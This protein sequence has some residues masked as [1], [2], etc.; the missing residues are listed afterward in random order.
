MN[1]SGE[2]RLKLIP[3]SAAGRC[4]AGRTGTPVSRW[5]IA[6]TRLLLSTV[7]EIFDESAYARFLARHSI[8]SCPNAYAAFLR[9]HETAKARRPKCC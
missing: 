2:P 1:G 3:T 6:A 8:S 9:E 7:R 4:S 5:F